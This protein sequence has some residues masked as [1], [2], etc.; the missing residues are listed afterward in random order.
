MIRRINNSSENNEDDI[1]EL[2]SSMELIALD[3]PIIGDRYMYMYRQFTGVMPVSGLQINETDPSRSSILDTFI[4]KWL[5]AECIWI[6]NLVG[7]DNEWSLV[8]LNT[9][10]LYDSETSRFMIPP[11]PYSNFDNTIPEYRDNDGW[12]VT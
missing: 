2:L 1:N 5:H 3:E 10:N 9:G 12:Y 4:F 7:A 8:N 11:P 6:K